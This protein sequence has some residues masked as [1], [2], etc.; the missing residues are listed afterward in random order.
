MTD[1]RSDDL[2]G[3]EGDSVAD[4]PDRGQSL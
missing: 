2:S 3:N 1:G 4:S